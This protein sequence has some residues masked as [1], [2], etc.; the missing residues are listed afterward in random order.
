MGIISIAAFR[1]HAGMDDDLTRVLDD[2]LPLLRRLGLATERPE[3]RAQSTSG[4]IITI[5]EWASQA[6][7]EEAHENLEVLA[8]WSRF[9]ACAHPVRLADLPEASEMFATFATVCVWTDVAD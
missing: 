7:I 5:S 3:V 4:V 9:E 8:L 6:A 1:A 2:R